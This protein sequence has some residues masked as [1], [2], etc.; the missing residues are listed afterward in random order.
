MWSTLNGARWSVL[1]AIPHHTSFRLFT[2]HFSVTRVYEK[3]HILHI[4]H[5]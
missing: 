4:L 1:S 5:K 3:V 2:L